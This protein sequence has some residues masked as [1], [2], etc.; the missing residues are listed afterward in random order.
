[1]TRR[2]AYSSGL[3]ARGTRLSDLFFLFLCAA[4]GT[5]QGAEGGNTRFW[6]L[7]GETITHLT[8]APT[9]TT[10]WGPD[11]CRNDPDGSVDFDERLRITGV[12]SGQYDVRF[13]DKAGRSCLVPNVAVKA[14]AVFSIGKEAL[15]NC[16][17]Q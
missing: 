10:K 15:T 1:M 8:M 3:R 12:S 9:G 6:N 14:G 11:Q 5:A 17:K 2:S 7:T 13:T 16:D 4:A